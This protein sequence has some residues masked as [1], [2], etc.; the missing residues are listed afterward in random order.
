MATQQNRKCA[1]CND[2]VADRRGFMKQVGGGAAAL[3]GLGALTP[4]VHAA[5]G[6]K[7]IT[8]DTAVKALYASLTDAQKE[9]MAF[10]FNHQLRKRVS[11]NWKITKALIGSDTFTKEQA[12]LIHGVLKTVLSE[13]GYDRM[14]RQTKADGGGIDRY[15]VALFGTPDS[16]D[17]FQFEMTG[18]HLT[19]RADGNRTD[20][21]AFGGPIVYGHAAEVPSRNLYFPETKATNK[22]FQALDDKQQKVALVKKSPRESAV[23]LQGKNGTFPGIGVSE[24]SDDQQELVAD[25]LEKLLSPYREADVKEVMSTLKEGGGLKSLNMAYYQDGDVADDKVWDVWRIE[26]P[27]FVWHFRGDPHVH[28]YINI[29]GA[30]AK[31]RQA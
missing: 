6:G 30:K 8:T 5:P 20:N 22:L 14:L 24:L 9:V 17:G 28:A 3:A 7:N 4:F 29:G 18:R 21:I 11:A 27:S 19:V 15:A 26:G 31:A 25:T 2:D 12:S 10:D 1:E 16:K 23:K 13:E